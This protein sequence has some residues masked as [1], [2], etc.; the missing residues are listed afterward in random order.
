MRVSI[1]TGSEEPVQPSLRDVKAMLDEFQSSPAPKSRCN[2][3]ARICQDCAD[4]S[5]LTGSEEPVQHGLR[6]WERR[7]ALVSILTGSEE[8]VQRK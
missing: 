8:P 2:R 1:L 4:V 7:E 5:I 6:A 3:T